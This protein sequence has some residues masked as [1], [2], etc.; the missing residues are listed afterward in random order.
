MMPSTLLGWFIGLSCATK[1]WTRPKPRPHLA[2]KKKRQFIRSIA[3][4]KQDQCFLT[5]AHISARI[6]K[7]KTNMMLCHSCAACQE[8][9]KHVACAGVPAWSSKLKLQTGKDSMVTRCVQAEVLSLTEEIIEMNTRIQQGKSKHTWRWRLW[10]SSRT[11]PGHTS[12]C[13]LGRSLGT[14]RRGAHKQTNTGPKRTEIR[15]LF[16]PISATSWLFF[17]KG[18]FSLGSQNK[19]RVVHKCRTCC[20]VS[21]NFTIVTFARGNVW[22]DRFWLLIGWVG[23]G[24]CFRLDNLGPAVGAARGRLLWTKLLWVLPPVA[25]PW[26]CNRNLVQ[27][28]VCWNYFFILFYFKLVLLTIATL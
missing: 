2:M 25:V 21:Q 16:S 27:R 22:K 19:C 7:R 20:G 8:P 23:F 15:A 5:H 10:S 3:W 11:P 6:I 28:S 12:L 14:A 1:Y 17:L 26:H 24:H 13:N 18:M 4:D 9:F